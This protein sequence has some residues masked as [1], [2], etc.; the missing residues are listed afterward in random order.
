MQ[1]LWFPE[2]FYKNILLKFFRKLYKNP[3]LWIAEKFIL[4]V[5]KNFIIS[6]F[7]KIVEKKL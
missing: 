5:C 4:V 6:Y 3:R 2:I 1:R 7:I